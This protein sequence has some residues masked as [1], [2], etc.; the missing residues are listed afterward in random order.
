MPAQFRAAAAPIPA[1]PRLY[2]RN[3]GSERITCSCGPVRADGRSATA[4]AASSKG[5]QRTGRGGEISPPHQQ[6][7]RFSKQETDATF[8]TVLQKLLGS[9]GQSHYGILGTPIPQM[10]QDIGRHQ[11]VEEQGPGPVSQ[12]VQGS[13]SVWNSS[14]GNAGE[15]GVPLPERAVWCTGLS[16]Y[17]HPWVQ[18]HHPTRSMAATGSSRA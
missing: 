10:Q 8:C 6:N 12:T 17:S 3:R 18:L 4:C 5:E 16:R 7:P 13:T 1:Q 14:T 11:C 15:E 9:R 2:Q